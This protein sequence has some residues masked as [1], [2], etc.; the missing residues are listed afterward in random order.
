MSGSAKL[1]Q[2]FLPLQITATTQPQ[3]FFSLK[4]S[5][6]FSETE[7]IA[8]HGSYSGKTEE[9][10]LVITY[11]TFRAVSA[12]CADESRDGTRV[13]SKDGST[14]PSTHSSHKRRG[15]RLLGMTNT[16][17]LSGAEASKTINVILLKTKTTTLNSP[18]DDGCLYLNIKDNVFAETS[19]C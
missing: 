1:L 6:T 12:F 10:A 8:A 5:R 4:V 3:E 11:R 2:P 18:R 16:R 9:S 15:I 19:P 7:S 13:A 14:R 17:T